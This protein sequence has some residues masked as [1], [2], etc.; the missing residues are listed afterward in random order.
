[1][2]KTD[3]VKTIATKS[4]ATQK[5]AEAMLKAFTDTIM[6]AVAKGDKV[7]MVGFGSFGVLKRKARPGRN[8]ATGAKIKIPA[9]KVPKFVPGKEFRSSVR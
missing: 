4:G 5:T 1:M 7:S 9:K 6:R 2:N 3:L 8:P